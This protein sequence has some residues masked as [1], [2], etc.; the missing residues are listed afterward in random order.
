[1]PNFPVVA[2]EEREIFAYNVTNGASFGVINHF[3]STACGGRAINWDSESGIAIYRYY[4]DGE[5]TAS[6]EFQP[7]LMAGIGFYP[8]SNEAE[9][10]PM[11]QPW[12]CMIFY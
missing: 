7:R 6:I 3:W 8:D 5:E 2:E 9:K 1:M 11:K 12:V 4:V 10:D